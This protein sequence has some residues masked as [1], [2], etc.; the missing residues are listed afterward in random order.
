M[1]P[2]L[3]AGLSEEQILRISTCSTGEWFYNNEATCVAFGQENDACNADLL[4]CAKSGEVGDLNSQ[5]KAVAE[6]IENGGTHPS[7]PKIENEG[8]ST[9]FESKSL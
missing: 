8:T 2:F 7:C 5:A 9:S 3:N 1:E 4:Y 6:A